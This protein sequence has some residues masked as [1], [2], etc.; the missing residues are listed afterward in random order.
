M[1][2]DKLG[3]APRKLLANS[4]VVQWITELRS[5]RGNIAESDDKQPMEAISVSDHFHDA[6]YQVAKAMSLIHILV[7]SCW[8]QKVLDKL[9]LTFV[10]TFKEPLVRSQ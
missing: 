4:N 2:T 3:L 6:K 9:R 1:K 7:T 8:S 10:C 5:I